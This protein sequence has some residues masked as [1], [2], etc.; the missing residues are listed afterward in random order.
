MSSLAPATPSV[1][2][3]NL[4]LSTP[5]P[6]PPTSLLPLHVRIRALLR[7]TC[8][9]T[10]TPVAGREHERASI[11]E[12]LAPFIDGTSMADDEVPSSMFISGS[13]GT[14]KT[15]LVNA[16]IRDLSTAD[17]SN[18]KVVFINCMAL[19]DVDALWERM[20][21]DLSDGP[22]RKIPGGKKAKGREAV[23]SLLDS[24][25]GKW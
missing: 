23:T 11:V 4:A 15:A 18:F 1:D 12:F 19:K 14:G 10:Q 17:Q 9:N 22:K 25:T 13:P 20:I 6:T 21:E 2:I 8:N 5:P 16:I 24:L 3:V 7:S